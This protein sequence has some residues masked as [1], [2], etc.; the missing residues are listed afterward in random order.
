MATWVQ[1]TPSGGNH[2]VNH[3]NLDLAYRIASHGSATRIYFVRAFIAG[4]TTSDH[5]DVV[6][7]LNTVLKLAGYAHA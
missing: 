1:L 7:P 3:F 2:A 5:V 4:S 6:E